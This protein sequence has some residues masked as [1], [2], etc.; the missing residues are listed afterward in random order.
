MA[1]LRAML[2][3]AAPRPRHELDMAAVRSRSQRLGVRRWLT[4]LGGIGAAIA[5]GVP[6]AGGLV[7]SP[8]D[9]AEVRVIPGP[10]STVPLTE[11]G[12]LSENDDVLA[13]SA[14]GSGSDAPAVVDRPVGSGPTATTSGSPGPASDYPAAPECS[15]DN[16][17]LGAGEQRRCRFT[18]TEPGGARFE[19]SGPAYPDGSDVIG[20]IFITRDGVTES[21]QVGGA[22]AQA[23]GVTGFATCDLSIRRGDLVE[24][25]LTNGR[26]VQ[27]TTTTLG[28][29]DRWTC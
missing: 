6:V 29:G 22:R 9:R 23:G 7:S 14:V 25:V 15:V 26:D 20:E 12:P 3:E 1:D 24:V 28:A 18:A 5:L 11:P 19:S 8:G 13:G 27:L 21:Y 10:T 2:H 4:W 17:G 16:D